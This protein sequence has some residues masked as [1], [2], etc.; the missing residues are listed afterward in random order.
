MVYDHL[1]FNA[2]FLFSRLFNLSTLLAC[3]FSASF[4]YLSF[5][6]F[7]SLFVFKAAIRTYIHFYS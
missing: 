6:A 7:A 2:L 4:S 3:I 1:S 5:S